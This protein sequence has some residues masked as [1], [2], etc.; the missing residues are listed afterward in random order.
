M[1]F[2]R[3]R[4]LGSTA[5]SASSWRVP[6]A[7]MRRVATLGVVVVLASASLAGVIVSQHAHAGT[8]AGDPYTW[9][10]NN[11]GNLGTG[12]FFTPSGPTPNHITTIGTS[13]ASVVSGPVANHVLAIGS[14]GS[15]WGWGDNSANEVNPSTTTQYAT[16]TQVPGIS[17][18]TAAAAGN[19]FTLALKSDGTVWAWGTNTSGQLGNGTTVASA[20]PVQVS[21]PAGVTIKAIA[22]GSGHSLAVDTNGNAWAWGDN[23]NGQLGNNSTTSSA[24]PVQVTMPAGVAVSS[25]AAGQFHSLAL[26][27]NGTLYSWGQ[28]TSGQLGLGSTTNA[29]VPTAVSGLAGVTSVAGG[30]QFSVAVTS[31]GVYTF[32]DNYD[33]ELGNGT[34]GGT[35][36]NPVLVS[37]LSG[38]SI[39]A[40]VAGDNHAVALASNGT[41]YAWGLSNNGQVGGNGG[42][43]A[44]GTFGDPCSLSP[45]T[46]PGLSNVSAITAGTQF[47]G[48]VVAASPV[49]TLSGSTLAFG[50][51]VQGTASVA[52]PI[53]VQN[54][55]GG[56]LTI[57]SVSVGGSNP[58]DFA[59]TDGCT[60]QSLAG[61]ASC[62]IGVTFTPGAIGARAATLSVSDNSAN[63]SPQTVSL[64]GSGTYSW[65][66][67]QFTSGTN[68]YRTGSKVGL[69]FQLTGASASITTAAATA[70]YAPVVNSVVG[71]Y[72]VTAGSPPNTGNNF[73][74]NSHSSNYQYTWSTKGL[75]AGTYSVK[76]T[77]DDGTTGTVTVIL[78]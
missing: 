47:S 74:Y 77:L 42:A 23:S 43:S 15:L 50:N 66:G 8:T 9:G 24:V 1:L 13:V 38:V 10:S 70:M 65:T 30:N 25:V 61:G 53:T 48:A 39:T 64:T 4:N 72:A 34:S 71:T 17:G 2:S 37:G 56:T 3:L 69:Q 49:A 51:Q 57:S 6:P 63:G 28:N 29:S 60:G 58:G 19:N 44:C 21:F 62:T 59:L 14:D 35:S 7:R 41:L 55:G 12:N 46:V 45:V 33:G 67:I 22:A 76:V 27:A 75:S 36:S 16:P 32:G 11:F 52:Q 20:T 5:M 31:S 73:S 78:Q 40:V 18:V 54:T 68:T 26:A